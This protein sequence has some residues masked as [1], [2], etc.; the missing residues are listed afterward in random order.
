M[1]SPVR[2]RTSPARVPN[3][4][5]ES[6][7]ACALR[8]FTAIQQ[9]RT[10]IRAQPMPTS[11]HPGD[12]LSCGSLRS[13]RT[14]QVAFATTHFVSQVAQHTTDPGR[15]RPDFQRDA[16]AAAS[17][18]KTVCAMLS[19]SSAPAAPSGSGRL[20]PPRST[21]LLRVS[22]IQSNGQFLL[23]KHSCSASTA[24]VLTFFIAG[25]LFICALSTSITW[26][27]TASRLETGLLIP[28]LTTTIWNNHPR[29]ETLRSHLM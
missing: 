20:H 11:A 3:H 19:L 29:L 13:A 4:S 27:R 5:S 10:S 7:C 1:N 17:V 9:L 8:C 28:L 25:L 14:L 23:A 26:E 22:E 2:A 16:T 12:R 21:R 15:M 18:P 6:A 24:V